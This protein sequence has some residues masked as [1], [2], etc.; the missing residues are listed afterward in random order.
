[1][2]PQAAVIAR[3]KHQWGCVAL[4]AA[5]LLLV[6]WATIAMVL[7]VGAA[8]QW[9][10]PALLVTGL[11][12]GCLYRVLD[13]NHEKNGR[14]LDRLGPANLITVL[15]GLLVALVSGFCLLPVSRLSGVHGLAWLP[16]V[17]FVAALLLDLVDG[18]VARRY[19]RITELGRLLDMRIDA[20]TV[21]CGS[22]LAALWAKAPGWFVLVGLAYYL[23]SLGCH[24]RKRRKKSCHPLPHSKLRRLLA[25]VM[26]T[27][28]GVI[29]FPPVTVELSRLLAAVIAVPFLIH[30]FRDFFLAAGVKAP[31]PKNA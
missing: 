14:L 10:A 11:V 1:M 30:F 20:L 23:F 27:T 26:M 8:M 15:R 2:N 22:L 12:L 21:L 29:L 24:L 19:D 4:W 13:R 5:A 17:L 25:G 16:G 18:A 31:F 9:L 6:F 3:L 7:G 28:I